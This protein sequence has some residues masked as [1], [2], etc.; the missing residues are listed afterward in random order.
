[1]HVRRFGANE[2]STVLVL[3]GAPSP[4]DDLLPLAL[5][6]STQHRVLLPDLP[7]YGGSHGG[8]LSFEVTSHRLVEMLEG[9]GCTA[10][11]AIV[12]FSGGV[13]RAL[14]LL[15]RSRVAATHVVSLGGIAGF[16]D[17]ERDQF[18]NLAAAIRR[19]PA[20]CTSPDMINMMS[21][22]MLSPR[23]R[24]AHPEDAE[25]V[26]H[27][28]TLLAPADLALELE[29]LAQTDD[30]RSELSKVT[31]KVYARVGELDQACPPRK[32]REIVD[33]V[34]VGELALVPSCGHALLIEDNRGTTDWVVG[35]L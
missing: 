11:H 2:S 22:R 20:V 4:P 30:F 3:H 10:L 29:A 15:L 32:S 21:S 27:W 31:A 8:D 9:E 12:G 26:G 16:D 23:W 25:R 14:H 5:A 6:L 19:R 7:G 28:T 17:D 1:M 34:P 13:L 24:A 18:R 33:R 35:S